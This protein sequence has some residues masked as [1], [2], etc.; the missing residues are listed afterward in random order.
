MP[1]F[2]VVVKHKPDLFV[3]LGDNI[4]GD[5]YNMDTLQAKYDKL[6]IKPTFQNLKKKIPIIATWD[7]HDFGIRMNKTR[8]AVEKTH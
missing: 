5:T 7:D 3:F 4:Y 6:S 2:D 1:I 8:A